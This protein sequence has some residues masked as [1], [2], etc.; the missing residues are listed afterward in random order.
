MI[1]ER[2]IHNNLKKGE[3]KTNVRIVEVERRVLEKERVQS[4]EDILIELVLQAKLSLQL[5]D[6]EGHSR[7]N[8]VRIYGMSG[9]EGK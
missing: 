9:G 3:I 6:Q 1:L 2:T 8:N 7:L 4:V 5:T